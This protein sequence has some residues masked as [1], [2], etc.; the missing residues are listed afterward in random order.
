MDDPKNRRKPT[1][2]PDADERNEERIAPP[3]EAVD[4]DDADES[5]DDVED[6][7]D[8]IEGEEGESR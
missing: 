8:A 1:D 6:E 7:D 3:D 4:A 2:A 5:F